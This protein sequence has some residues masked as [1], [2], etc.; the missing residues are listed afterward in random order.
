MQETPKPD[1]ID[2]WSDVADLLGSIRERHI[3]FMD[4]PTGES[5]L[6]TFTEDTWRE[7]YR[8]EVRLD[9]SKMWLHHYREDGE[10]ETLWESSR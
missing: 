5:I 7:Q 10:S 2:D 1:E 9:C 4:R 8:F 6:F 3:D